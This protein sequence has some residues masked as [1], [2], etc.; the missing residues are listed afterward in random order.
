MLS[1]Y[2][3]LFKQADDDGA[4][5][6]DGKTPL[7]DWVGRML[8]DMQSAIEQHINNAMKGASTQE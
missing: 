6:P 1:K 4:M 3:F 5:G 2:T 8:G 7:R